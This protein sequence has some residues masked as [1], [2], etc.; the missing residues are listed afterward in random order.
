[1]TFK[2]ILSKSHKFPSDKIE[3]VFVEAQVINV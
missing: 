1:M 2:T 3:K